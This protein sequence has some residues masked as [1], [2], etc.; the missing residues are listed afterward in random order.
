ME[1]KTIIIIVSVVVI[2]ICLG[3]GLYFLLRDT[4]QSS[5]KQFI[6]K[7]LSNDTEAFAPDSTSGDQL[8]ELKNLQTGPDEKNL[9]TIPDFNKNKTIYNINLDTAAIPFV[10]A[11]PV[12][13]SAKVGYSNTIPE[14]PNWT[15]ASKIITI[16]QTDKQTKIIT[17][18]YTVK[19]S[20]SDEYSTTV[21][22]IKDKLKNTHGITDLQTLQLTDDTILKLDPLITTMGEFSTSSDTDDMKYNTITS[23]FADLVKDMNDKDQIYKV[24]GLFIIILNV[25]NLE[26]WIHQEKDGVSYIYKDG[27]D[28]CNNIVPISKFNVDQTFYNTYLEEIKSGERLPDCTYFNLH[29]IINAM[30][31]TFK[32]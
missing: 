17:I 19:E 3:V 20:E 4:A 29:L 5:V 13:K 8:I 30:I 6:K 21:D 24:T 22:D 28:P 25:L 1:K 2:L 23:K 18:N 11:T 26:N 12:N 10:L 14:N 7:N 27:D 32:K 9:T 15:N 16:T 31:K